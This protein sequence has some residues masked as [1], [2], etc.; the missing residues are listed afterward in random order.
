[1]GAPLEDASGAL[2]RLHQAA[3][4]KAEALA[5]DAAFLAAI[6]KLGAGGQEAAESV[7]GLEPDVEAETSEPFADVHNRLSAE[8]PLVD[9]RD[10]G[11]LLATANKLESLIAAY[12]ARKHALKIAAKLT[13]ETLDAAETLLMIM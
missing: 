12:G 6:P 13:G 2:R 9:E 11:L 5:Q 8:R 4:E 1:M 7:S 10:R 3:L